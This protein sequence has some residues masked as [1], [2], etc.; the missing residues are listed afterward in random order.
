MN[1]DSAQQ[2][3]KNTL[4]VPGYISEAKSYLKKL[5]TTFSNDREENLVNKLKEK[6][7]E[8]TEIWERLTPTI[9]FISKSKEYIDLLKR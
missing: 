2:F 5:E 4:A 8:K 1:Y 3:R 7:V 9:R 6:L